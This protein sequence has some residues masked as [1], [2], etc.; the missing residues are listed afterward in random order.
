MK[1]PG[2]EFASKLVQHQFARQ[3][4]YAHRVL[5]FW[6][7]SFN[8]RAFTKSPI[9][10]DTAKLTTALHAQI[11]RQFRTILEECSRCETAGAEITARCL[12]EG[13][14]A[15]IFLTQP[16]V[17]VITYPLLDK[18]GKQ[19]QTQS[20]LPRWGVRCL[21]KGERRSKG[22]F[23]PMQLR[24][25]L[26]LAHVIFQ[27]ESDARKCRALP[28][29]KRVGKMLEGLTDPA[30]VKRCQT[31]VGPKWE[32]I[33][34]YSNSYSGLSTADLATMLHSHLLRWYVK[35]Y[36]PQSAL[37]HGAMA[38]VYTKLNAN[39]NIEPKYLSDVDEV[40]RLVF[41]GTLLFRVFLS[42]MQN[43]IGFGIAAESGV[44]QLIKEF[45][46]VFGY[47]SAE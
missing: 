35:M 37:I 26:Y 14:L 36:G 41:V 2:E 30:E 44:D 9:P 12:F 47:P 29:A 32:Y 45:D 42:T 18:Q 21:K 17:H 25:N 15:L 43:N 19:K 5:R 46:E 6:L 4:E 31:S 39:G 1:F 33:L 3:F 34:R 23:L 28:G 20:G 10:S 8:T 11:C 13:V 27:H 22:N 16:N 38:I 24:A 40:W 7:N